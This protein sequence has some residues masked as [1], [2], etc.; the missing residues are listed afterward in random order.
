MYVDNSNAIGKKLARKYSKLSRRFYA[1]HKLCL[2]GTIYLCSSFLAFYVYV[3]Y[4]C[5]FLEY[6]YCTDAISNFFTL[7]FFP[8]IDA[9]LF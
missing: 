9:V 6:G 4:A 3:Q 1:S 8:C 7:F 5:L 2:N